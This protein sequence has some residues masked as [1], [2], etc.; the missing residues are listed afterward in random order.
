MG[1]L[2]AEAVAGV[3]R[4]SAE[5]ASDCC[6]SPFSC[7]AARQR[8]GSGVPGRSHDSAFT[9]T[10]HSAFHSANHEYFMMRNFLSA[11]MPA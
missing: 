6:R 10:G 9:T 2:A 5:D 3:P 1:I 7:Q 4:F 11:F 8:P